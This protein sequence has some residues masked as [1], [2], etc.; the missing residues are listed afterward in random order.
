MVSV[1]IM[2]TGGARSKR[3]VSLR[4]LSLTSPRLNPRAR[5]RREEIPGNTEPLSGASWL[6]ELWLCNSSPSGRFKPWLVEDMF[7][8]SRSGDA[9]RGM[10]PGGYE[11]DCAISSVLVRG[12]SRKGEAR[13]EGSST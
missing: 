3:R 6:A 11:G 2:S 1:D 8:E 12:T 10:G 7:K 13:R 4:E 5:M 9:S